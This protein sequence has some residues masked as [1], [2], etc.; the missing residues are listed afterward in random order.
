MKEHKEINIQE[1]E[2]GISEMER[3]MHEMNETKE[4]NFVVLHNLRYENY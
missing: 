2:K 3:N 4:K 1:M